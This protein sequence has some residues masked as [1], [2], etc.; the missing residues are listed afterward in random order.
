MLKR[1]AVAAS[2]GLLVA[3]GNGVAQEG[4]KGAVQAGQPGAGPVVEPAGQPEVGR[5]IHFDLEPT[6]W[7][8]HSATGWMARSWKNR[9]P[10]CRIR[11]T[12]AR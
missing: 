7:G 12:T 6:Y 1:W 3:A 10:A 8:R 11:S 4:D 2:I 5:A 9:N